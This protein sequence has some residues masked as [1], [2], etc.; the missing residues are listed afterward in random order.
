MVIIVLYKN[1]KN[2]YVVAETAFYLSEILYLVGDQL[3]DLIVYRAR[4]GINE[5]V[6]DS[7]ISLTPAFWWE[8]TDMNWAAACGGSMGAAALYQIEDDQRLIPIIN[9][10]FP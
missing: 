1:T 5:R 9:P 7:F 3:S 4:K 2:C 8:S 6:L 10:K